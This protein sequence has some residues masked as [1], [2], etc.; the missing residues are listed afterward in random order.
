MSRAASAGLPTAERWDIQT[1][2]GNPPQEKLRHYT[3]LTG[4]GPVMTV[5]AEPDWASTFWTV[6]QDRAAPGLPALGI[7]VDQ[8]QEA[9]KSGMA[10]AG[11]LDRTGSPES[12]AGTI[13]PEAA[14]GSGQNAHVVRLSLLGQVVG[15]WVNER[16]IPG[17]RFSW[18]P[19]GSGAIRY[20]A[21]GGRLV[22]FDRE[23]RT[24]AV[25]DVKD[26]LLPAW[27]TDGVRLCTS[28]RQ[29]ARNTRSP[30]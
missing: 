27:S 26:A 17:T 4:G 23:K 16:V 11:A 1:G 19:D 3:V 30:G 20:V 2:E 9:L 8:R 28:R 22:L 21:E 5:D 24:Q 13:S 10:P 29:D 14:A 15:S 18:G 12:T 7:Q 6:K 25:K